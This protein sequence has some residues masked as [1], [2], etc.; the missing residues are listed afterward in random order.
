MGKSTR[1]KIAS[2]TRT[3]ADRDF[4]K[5]V[6]RASLISLSF[7][8]LVIGALF[9]LNPITEGQGSP[10]A[11]PVA[12]PA[13]TATSTPAASSEREVAAPLPEKTF[14]KSAKDSYS[15]PVSAAP[16]SLR[17]SSLSIPSVGINADV[18]S[19]GAKDG[20]MVLPESS[21]T[22]EYT[23]ASPLT[24]TEG[25][26]VIAGHVN[27]EDGTPGALGTLHKIEKGAPVYA[28]DSKG[29]VHK[30]RVVAMDVLKKQALPYSIFRTSGDRQLVIVTCGGDIETVNGV[31][32]YANNLVVTAEPVI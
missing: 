25:S 10:S 30:Y 11:F 19:G 1:S 14:D 9:V 27:F 6:V 12:N 15:P 16:V 5:L 17:P 4:R 32:V 29:K 7:C 28:T 24:D 23:G 2:K 13:V 18:V 22:A 26:T 20:R 8:V 21:K 31:P 3:G